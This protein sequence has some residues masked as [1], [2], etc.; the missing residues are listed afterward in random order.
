[1]VQRE[2]TMRIRLLRKSTVRPQDEKMWMGFL[3][4]F[5]EGIEDIVRKKR[6]SSYLIHLC[7]ER[8][9]KAER[10]TLL[11]ILNDIVL[12]ISD[13]TSEKSESQHSLSEV[14]LKNCDSLDN[15]INIF[16]KLQTVSD[17]ARNPRQAPKAGATVSSR[18][19]EILE[20]I[21]SDNHPTK[22]GN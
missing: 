22:G 18:S 3:L 19:R 12:S 9:C 10:R 11:R 8:L 1:M 6:K 14:V 16:A 4:T 20:K 2:A 5:F 13:K 15:L 21:Q 7:E 17:P